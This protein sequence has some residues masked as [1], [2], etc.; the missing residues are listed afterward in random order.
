VNTDTKTLR[1]LCVD[2]DV[3]VLS[4]VTDMLGEQGHNVETAIDGAHALQK[5]A[6]T[7]SS[8]DVIIADGRMPHLDGWRL[9]MQARANG[10]AGKIILFSAWLNDE[11][12]ERYG[13]LRVDAL[14]E[15]PPGR[16]E[17]VRVV[18]QLAAA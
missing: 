16:G 1:I 13:R 11:E 12:R 15:K 9:I 2:D 7:D 17:L 10:Y 3:H 6:T 4:L 5:L 18:N 14:L 8:Y